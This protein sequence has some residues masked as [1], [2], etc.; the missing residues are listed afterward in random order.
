MFVIA[1]CLFVRLFLCLLIFKNNYQATFVNDTHAQ[2]IER[3]HRGHTRAGYNSECVILGCVGAGDDEM[4]ITKL[5][6]PS[7]GKFWRRSHRMF[8]YRAKSGPKSRKFVAKN[9]MKPSKLIS[10]MC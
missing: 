9:V 10:R 3:A 8:F 7:Y 6:C 4:T 1:C 5:L 2:T